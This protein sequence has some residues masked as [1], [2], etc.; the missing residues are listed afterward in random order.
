MKRRI[1][2]SLG[3]LLIEGSFARFAFSALTVDSYPDSADAPARQTRRDFGI[4]YLIGSVIFAVS[5]VKVFGIAHSEQKQ[6]ADYRE[7]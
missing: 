6:N 4:Y 1:R 2:K 5:A 7:K 3:R